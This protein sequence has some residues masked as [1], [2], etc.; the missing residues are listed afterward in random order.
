MPVEFAQNN[1]F[2]EKPLFKWVAMAKDGKKK[3]NKGLQRHLFAI[4]VHLKKVFCTKKYYFA[5][6]LQASLIIYANYSFRV[7]TLFKGLIC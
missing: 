6:T 3:G 5:Q 4:T 7:Q 2:G 1:I